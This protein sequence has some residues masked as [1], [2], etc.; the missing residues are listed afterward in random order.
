[1]DTT[2]VQELGRRALRQKGWL[3][4][5]KWLIFRRSTQLSILAL[6]LIGPFFGIWILKGN[7]NSSV[8][9][10]T[11]PLSDPYILLQ[12]L[13]TG[14]LPQ[15]S[16]ILGALLVLAFYLLVGGRTYCSWVCPINIV[17]DFA[18]WLRNKLNIKSTFTLSR[19]TRYWIL[20]MTLLLTGITGSLVWEFVNPVSMVSRAIVFGLGLAW[21]AVLIIFLLDTF[22]SRRAWCGHLC[23]MG[24]FYS[25]LGKLSLIR[26]N[27]VA[28]EQC[29]NCMECYAVCPEQKVIT[30][31]LKRSG[32]QTSLISDINCTHC[33]RCIDIC[34]TQVFQFDFR[35]NDVVNNAVT[36]D[37]TL[38]DS[39][40]Q[41]HH[42]EV[43]S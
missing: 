33:G 20:G 21:V 36:E 17:T 22:I 35:Y 10:D 13:F 31:V 18:M 15:T 28:L 42:N 29:D 5:H 25:L 19:E 39:N 16:A 14:Y 9:L 8:I 32:R 2:P 38:I 27:A 6:F 7:L 37:Q 34:S 23:P 11:V 26:V 3:K 30:P 4:A 12:T 1:M 40:K 41:S 43:I 24:A